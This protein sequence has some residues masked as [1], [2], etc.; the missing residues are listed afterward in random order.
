MLSNVN[1]LRYK[2]I[3]ESVMF[4]SLRIEAHFADI[5]VKKNLADS[6]LDKEIS[7]A[8][9]RLQIERRFQKWNVFVS[10]AILNV[11]N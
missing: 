4:F 5:C 3:P 11:C 1:V 7:L 6:I 8:L 9:I 2:C 10:P